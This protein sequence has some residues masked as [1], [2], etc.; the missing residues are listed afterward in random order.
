MTKEEFKLRWDKDENGDGITVDDIADCAVAWKLCTHPKTLPIDTVIRM[1][2][3][4]S[5]APT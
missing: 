3:I 5:G 4:A 1:V 2:V